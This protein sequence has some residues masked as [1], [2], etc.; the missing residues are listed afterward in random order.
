MEE[1]DYWRL[2][3]ELTVVQAALLVVGANP[4]TDQEYVI[5]WEPYQ[6]PNGFDAAMA[7][8]THAILA[9]SPSGDYPQNWM[10]AWMERRPRRR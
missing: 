4:S 10:G 2:C 1:M 6:R 7:A 3:D 5:G 8:L 9:G